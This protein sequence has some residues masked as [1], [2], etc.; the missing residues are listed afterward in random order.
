MVNEEQMSGVP[1]VEQADAYLIEAEVM[2][3]GQWVPHVK[4]VA[5]AAKAIADQHPTLDADAA[6]ALGCVHD[7]GRRGGRMGIRHIVEGHAFMIAEGFPVAGRI[8]LTHSYPYQDWAFDCS[9]WD[10]EP[11]VC[12]DVQAFI[13]DV[14]YDDY[15][16][17]IQLCDMLA[18]P[19]GFCLLEKR[20]VEGALRHGTSAQLQ[21]K[22][23]ETFEIQD[24][25]ESSI[26]CSIYEL[27]PGVVE[28][29]FPGRSNK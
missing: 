26:G 5:Q 3:P 8:C 24:R 6:Y 1:T 29:T 19:E 13:R 4:Y 21:N 18:L 27:L 23:R 22:W 12:E 16:R 11:G 10:C 20:M 15:D 2:N 7:I 14:E 25:F 28:N 9:T 17:L